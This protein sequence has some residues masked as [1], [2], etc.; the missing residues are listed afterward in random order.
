M[1]LCLMAQRRSQDTY[2][3][4]PDE[5]VQTAQDQSEN[6][7][8]T[9]K[10]SKSDNSEK[11]DKSDKKT[12]TGFS[13]GMMIHGG[14]AFSQ[15]PNELFRNGSLNADKL[16]DLPKD[17]FAFGLGGTLRLHLLDH[18]HLGGDGHMS[19]MPLMSSSMRA[20]PQ[21]VMS[22]A[23]S[24][25]VRAKKRFVFIRAPP[26]FLDQESARPPPQE[27]RRADRFSHGFRTHGHSP[28]RKKKRPEGRVQS[29]YSA[30]WRGV[31]CHGKR[32]KPNTE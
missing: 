3:P 29:G 13:G 8:S 15:T 19:F 7:K 22:A 21:Q 32:M 10:T 23:S 17:G 9:R 11:S 25:R 28:F 16:G 6:N 2:K 4:A 31:L 1:P 20:A 18:I 26:V 5:Q 12:L 30:N 27:A 14:Y 24:A